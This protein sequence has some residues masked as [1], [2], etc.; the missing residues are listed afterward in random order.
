MRIN[1]DNKIFGGNGG[2]AIFIAIF[3]S[4]LF[5]FVLPLQ[6]PAKLLCVSFHATMIALNI[7]KSAFGFAPIFF[8]ILRTT[9]FI[10]PLGASYQDIR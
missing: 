8:S 10:Y 4:F 3:F 1:N 7:L 5:V 2:S 6:L 9:S